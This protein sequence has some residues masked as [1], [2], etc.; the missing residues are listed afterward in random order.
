MT[1]RL[2]SDEDLANLI[3]FGFR[4][5]DIADRFR[6]SVPA[7]S[8]AARRLGFRAVNQVEIHRGVRPVVFTTRVFLSHIRAA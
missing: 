2:P 4:Y 3:R 8:K 1:R 5:T 7:V 6:V